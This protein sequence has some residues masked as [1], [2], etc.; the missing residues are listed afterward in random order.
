MLNLCIPAIWGE[1][2]VEWVKEEMIVLLNYTII[3]WDYGVIVLSKGKAKSPHGGE[4]KELIKSELF[5]IFIL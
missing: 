2:S 3:L 4:I 1:M 5:L